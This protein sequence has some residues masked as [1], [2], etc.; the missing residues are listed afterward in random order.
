MLTVDDGYA[1]NLRIL[2]VLERWGAEA[3]FLISGAHVGNGLRFWPDALYA[4]AARAGWSVRA[5]RR[6]LGRLRLMRYE[7]AVRCLEGWFGEDVMTTPG[8]LGRPMTVAELRA[9]ASSPHVEIGSHAYHHTVLTP[10]PE[11]FV[12]DELER[13]IDFLTAIVGQRPMTIS[14]PNGLYSE[15]LKARCRRLGF[16]VGLT[17]EARAS[18]LREGRPVGDLMQLGR[19]TVSGGRRLDRQLASAVMARSAMRALY[20]FKQSKVAEDAI[21]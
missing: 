10:R 6:A 14:Y 13:S 3:V 2:P 12:H 8:D 17:I 4:G 18:P 11:R 16:G 1:D 15:T 21:A 5:R 19:F 7:E 20:G 9:L